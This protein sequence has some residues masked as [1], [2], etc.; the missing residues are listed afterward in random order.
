M[1]LAELA[2]RRPRVVGGR[3]RAPD[4]PNA[5]SVATF[6]RARTHGL[7][8]G[9]DLDDSPNPA[10]GWQAVLDT[11]APPEQSS[12]IKVPHHGSEDADHDGVSET[13]IEDGAVAIVTSFLVTATVADL[14]PPT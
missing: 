8:L 1:T 10:A 9:A 11:A 12:V 3:Y 2:F 14:S 6:A 13:L 7:L 5:A 4:R